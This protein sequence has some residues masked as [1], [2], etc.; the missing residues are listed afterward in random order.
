MARRK[1]LTDAY[2]ASLKPKAKRYAVADPQLPSF[3]VG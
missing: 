2:I 3:Y 1:Q